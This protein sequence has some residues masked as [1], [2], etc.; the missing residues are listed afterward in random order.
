M[1]V[2][3]RWLRRCYT[4]RP[5]R[6]VVPLFLLGVFYLT[7]YRLPAPAGGETLSLTP[8]ASRA[9]L[10]V[11]GEL[12]EKGRY[13]EALAATER[14][15]QSYPNNHIY[16]YRLAQANHGLGCYE[17]EAALLEHYMDVA[18]IPGAVCLELL[19]AYARQGLGGAMMA[20]AERCL[21]LDP[22]NADTLYYLAR[23]YEFQAQREEAGALYR[24][25]LALAPDYLDMGLGLGRIGLEEGRVEEA[26]DTAAAV[27]E[28]YPEHPDA[29][30]LLGSALRHAGSLNEAKGA[31]E[32]GLS[33][34]PGYRDFYLLLGSL[35]EQLGDLAAASLYYGE[36]HEL[37]AQ[38]CA[39]RRRR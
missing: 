3:Y 10:G 8:E 4:S 31:L 28:R 7:L 23:A 35:S 19:R 15:Y 27:L 39:R 17:E 37:E 24:E 26:R 29:L 16:L 25:G 21:A 36:A 32:R 12:L 18:P 38:L 5:G 2:L 33:L 13:E 11:S 22:K 30:L 14:L 34:Y 1:A 6:I 9:L 20:A